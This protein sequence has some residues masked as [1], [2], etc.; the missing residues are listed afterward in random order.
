MALDK[1]KILYYAQNFRLS[2]I[3]I[4][5]D[6]PIAIRV[7][8]QILIQKDDFITRADVKGFIRQIL[9]EQRYQP[10]HEHNNADIVISLGEA[11]FKVNINDSSV[12]PV[13]SYSKSQIDDLDIVI[14]I[15]DIRFRINIY[16]TITG[17]A[18]V[19]R[20]IHTVIPEIESLGLPPS[21][22][23]VTKEKNG[24]VLI[25]GATG[26]GKSTSIAA[27]INR[28]NETRSENI[29]TI[30]D[31]V[32][33][34]H[35]CKSSIVSQ[36]EIGKDTSSFAQALRSALREDP[37]VILVGELRDLETISLALTAAETGHLVFGTLHT[38]GAPNTINRILDVFPPNQQNQ[39][40]TQLSQSLRLVVTQ[41]L[42]KRIDKDQRVAAFEVM[43]NNA[44]SNLIRENKVFQI[45][46]VM[47]TGKGAGMITMKDSL[48]RLHELG[49][50]SELDANRA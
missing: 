33:F 19:L 13:P 12:E 27:I 7:N 8:G 35:T 1:A 40:R 4:L 17:P 38:N 10:A 16:N 5:S 31:P 24:L 46:Q 9:D 30:E 42:I 36:R 11:S 48:N 49:I 3:H 26:A 20:K 14:S 45:E 43:V 50:I 6:Q 37:D 25:T 2:D 18:M 39:A 21:V 44:V 32:E 28:I 22:I 29:I 15:E 47:Q 41:Q 34:V 23:E